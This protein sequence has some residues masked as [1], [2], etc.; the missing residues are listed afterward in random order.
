[1]RGRRIVTAVSLAGLL[2]SGGVVPAMATSSG[3][4]SSAASQNES[5]DKSGIA[6][7]GPDAFQAR[8]QTEDQA[9]AFDAALTAATQDRS[10]M[11]YPWLDPRTNTVELRPVTASGVDAARAAAPKVASKGVKV[12]TDSTAPSIAELDVLQDALTHLVD[13]GAPNA[14]LVWMTEPDQQN[15]RVIVTV[16]RLDPAL[17]S[18][19]AARFGTTEI[20][21]RV[22]DAGP[23][24][25]ASR[26][27]DVSPYFGGAYF[28]TSTGKACTTGF[29]WTTG[30]GDGM[31]TAAHCISTGGS[32]SY[33][34]AANVGTVASGSAENWNDTN[35]T[36]FYTG[37]TVYRGDVAMIKYKSGFGSAGWIFTAN[38]TAVKVKTIT[39]RFSN[40]GDAAC[41]NGVT[42]GEWCGA[43]TGTGINVL[44]LVNGINTWARNVVRAESGG[45]PCPTHGDSGAPVYR[46]VTGGVAAVGIYSG[47][48]PAVVACQAYFTDIRDS[49][50]ALPGSLKVTP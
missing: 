47:G 50:I 10:A 20:A 40:I 3:A 12:T 1:M 33:P 23:A 38:T 46:K 6:I 31:L 5:V 26:L 18:Y 21:V 11:G 35:G 41:V 42:T 8:P 17:M 29:P 25:A 49:L 43:V 24:A 34:S 2:A 9:M 19:L 32:V 45:N 13:D 30:S 44:Y 16:S 27:S 39:S 15:G 37:Q 28:T 22:Q 36:Q 4:G 48:L 7:V 14:T